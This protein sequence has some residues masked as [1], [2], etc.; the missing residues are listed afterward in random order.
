[1]KILIL[2]GQG[3]LGHK[4]FQI[5][6]RQFET[7]V[8]FQKARGAWQRFPMYQNAAA[9][10]I[11]DVDARQFDTVVAALA[12]VRP[13]VVINCIGIIKQ[14]EAAKNPILSL[15]VNALFPHRLALLCGAAGSK[16]IQISTD[17]VFSGNKGGYTE[18]D[19]PDP[20]D[21]YGRSKL[22]GEV[23][24]F[25]ALTL[26]TSIIGRD[27]VKNIGLIEWLW[28][29]RGQQIKGFTHAIYS[30]FSTQALVELMAKII[31][32]HPDLYGLYHV[33][34]NP[35]SKYE[36]LKRVNEAAKLNIKIDPDETFYCD[37]SLNANLFQTTTGLQPP[38]WKQMINNIV[39][40]AALYEQWRIQNEKFGW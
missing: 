2:G 25:P 27:F 11:T 1:M 20:V 21:L 39:D 15:E 35:I 12:Q 9:Y 16:L 3:M 34:S 6:S 8:T 36:L 30:G 37:R 5:L 17:C 19:N 31:V 24:R 26:R 22:L 38:S 4:A 14:L 7:Y 23:T 33:A 29:N 28:G 40:E 32:N 13:D 18:Q 10:T